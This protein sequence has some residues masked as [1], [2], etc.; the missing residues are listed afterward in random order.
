MRVEGIDG[1]IYVA[2]LTASRI[3]MRSAPSTPNALAL[4][5]P[6]RG[7]RGD[8]NRCCVSSKG[9]RRLGLS[10]LSRM[11]LQSC[12][13]ISHKVDSRQECTRD[14]MQIPAGIRRIDST[15]LVSK[16]YHIQKLDVKKVFKM[17]LCEGLTGTA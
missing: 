17:V 11:W 4:V 2:R 13:W 6:A 12:A 15:G 8:Q 16:L 1:S 9:S 14:H 5:E 3:G 10:S 7:R